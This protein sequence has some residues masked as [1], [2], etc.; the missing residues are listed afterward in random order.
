M[1]MDVRS[2]F[3]VPVVRTGDGDRDIPVDVDYLVVVVNVPV[4]AS[5]LGD[6][7]L[8]GFTSSVLRNLHPA[9][10]TTPALNMAFSGLLKVSMI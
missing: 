7:T 6:E 9:L 2:L 8:S 1:D 4:F 3:K 5:G 10:G